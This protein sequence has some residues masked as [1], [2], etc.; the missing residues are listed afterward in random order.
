[1]SK[2]Q[3]PDVVRDK[4]GDL[5]G[6]VREPDLLS[7]IA[8]AVADPRID[9]EKM[10]RLLAMHEKITT[11]Q[12]R[13]DF[14]AALAR[15]Q[16]VI[17]QIKKSGMILDKNGTLRSRYAKIEHIDAILRPLLAEE[18]F[19]MSFNSAA[20]PNGGYLLSCTLSHQAG[21]SEVKSLVLPLD[22][23]AFR[24]DV[25]SVGSTVSYGRRVLQKMHL[26]LIETEEDD[27]GQG[28]GEKISKDQALDFEAA[29]EET[30]GNPM[31]FLKHMEA[32]SFSDILVRD[33]PKAVAAID[34]KRRQS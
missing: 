29:V 8:A 31:L 27:D 9:V 2:A 18:G 33:I 25:Q 6:P 4:P 23:S 12:R 19:A 5:T 10:E 28:G 7:V 15:I 24:T 17:P 26:N 30:K 34:K 20:A 11:E 1:M 16:A 3:P 21:H 22:K 13:I 32:A 14:F